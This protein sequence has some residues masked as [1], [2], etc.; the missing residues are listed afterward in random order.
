MQVLE[1]SLGMFS[2]LFAATLWIAI[3]TKLKMPVST[4][5]AL[6]GAIVGF[7]W[8]EFGAG[9]VPGVVFAR[10]LLPMLSSPLLGA[11][12]T[13]ASLRLIRR[14]FLQGDGRSRVAGLA[15]LRLLPGL[16]G[17]TVFLLGTLVALNKGFHLAPWL[18]V[19]IG[20][21]AGLL[22]AAVV[23][24]VA[25]PRVAATF[26]AM[27][28]TITVVTGTE[29]GYL[30]EIF[31]TRDD[32]AVAEFALSADE[33]HAAIPLSSG[34]TGAPRN[35]R[36]T[37]PEFEEPAGPAY[38]HDFH[39]QL[40][41]YPL[42]LSAAYVSFSHGS[43]DVSHSVAPLAAVF[44]AMRTHTSDDPG[45]P[46]WILVYA[47]AGIV[48]GLVLWGL[49]VMKTVGSGITPLSPSSG[50]A[51]QISTSAVVLTASLLGFPVSSTHTI[52]GA[53]LGVA[54]VTGEKVDRK[55]L[56][57][58]GLSWIVTFPAGAVLSA[59]VY[60]LGKLAVK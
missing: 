52:I 42:W 16:W 50:F 36:S 60:S 25:L 6:V 2:T 5:H 51:A 8:T 34:A 49:P 14:L 59:I 19:V 11:A 20:A 7:A 4:T 26:L 18:S 32:D 53:I 28:L 35:A 13:F 45:V 21:G 1:Y 31:A 23:Y 54:L 47:A 40:F 41:V 57:K 30:E 43:N 10:L 12:M 38:L 37:S 46:L 24:I 48:V 55:L 27:P 44:H 58:I 56:K 9:S 29:P 22:S 15:S 33:H 39:Q 17:V 3:A